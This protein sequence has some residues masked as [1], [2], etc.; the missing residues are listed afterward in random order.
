MRNHIVA[1]FIAGLLL[2]SAG[3]ASAATKTTTFTVSASVAANCFVSATNM[4]F[5][6]YTGV[7][8]LQTTSDVLVRCTSGSPD[9]LQLSKGGGAF[10]QRLLSDGGSNTLQYN[11]YSNAARTNIWGDGTAST[12]TVGGTGAGLGVPN[13]VTHTVYG[14]LPNSAANL[15]A[16]VGNYSDTITVTIAY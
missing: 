3:T 5:G 1:P 6:S 13:Q 15:T 9:T 12:V 16:P 2:A 8:A 7:A 14:D 10:A 11:L 4:A